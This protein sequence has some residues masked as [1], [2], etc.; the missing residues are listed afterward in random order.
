[1]TI[2]VFKVVVAVPE[3]KTQPVYGSAVTVY[4]TLDKSLIPIKEEDDSEDQER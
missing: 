2:S 4:F 1:M 3:G